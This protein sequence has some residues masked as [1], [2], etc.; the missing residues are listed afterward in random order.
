MAKRALPEVNAGSMADIAFLLLIFF[1]VTTTI[2]S[3]TGINRKL[4]PK[5]DEE[6]ITPPKIKEKNLF[7][8]I[9][10][11]NNQLLVEDENMELKNLREAAIAFLDNGGGTK[12][13]LGSKYCDYCRGKRD[14]E[15]SDNP[16]KA[17]IS[18]QNSRETNYGVYIGIQNE[19]VAAYTFLRNREAKRLYGETYQSMQARYKDANDLEDKD[20]LK[21]KLDEVK[22]LYPEKLSE[23]EAPE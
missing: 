22:K 16:E 8:V 10:N 20:E 15:S 21:A 6:N 17:V 19:L 23:A 14:P 9:V 18:L 7:T 3:D 1:L 5:F 2:A 4:P 11:K 13:D 12:A